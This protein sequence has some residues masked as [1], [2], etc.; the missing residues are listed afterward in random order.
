MNPPLHANTQRD[1]TLD[2]LRG[3]AALAVVL[4][5]YTMNAGH[6]AYGLRLGVTGVD[7]FFI[8]SGFVIFMTLTRTK[9]ARDFIVSRFIRLYPTYWACVTFTFL[10]H[11]AHAM[12]HHSFTLNYLEQYLGN[13]TM[14]QHY[15]GLPD[16]DGPY[17]TMIVEMVFYLTMLLI[18]MA[19]QLPRIERIGSVI[20]AVCFLTYAVASR[21]R[22]EIYLTIDFFYPLLNHF[23]LFF[24]GI[25]FYLIKHDR[26]TVARY[27]MLC[28]C[29]IASLF[30][31]HNLV[32]NYFISY[33]EHAAM[34]VLYYLVFT[35]Y[36]NSKLSYLAQRPIIYLGTISYALYLVHQSLS[37]F[38]LRPFLRHTF[39]DHFWL[40]NLVMLAISIGLASAI[41]F[42]I[43][44]PAMRVLKKKFRIRKP[45]SF[46]V[47][48]A[49]QSI[50][51]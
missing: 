46:S 32:R 20:M 7:L 45:L 5:H 39:G 27:A 15:L 16:I 1:F 29:F 23:P 6:P 26:P 18:F 10:L 21:V 44:K 41:T 42:W 33:T 28:S 38:F 43:E 49:E 30:V 4:F 47:S 17:W 40:N 3:I 36:I 13:L 8:I 50:N 14:F 22:P 2:A 34:L 31:Y 9:T 25:L 12:R 19:K 35:L 37:L 24:A 51:Y 11:A 48:S